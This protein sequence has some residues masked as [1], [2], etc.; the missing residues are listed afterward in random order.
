MQDIYDFSVGFEIKLHFCGKI[1]HVKRWNS[2]EK[3]YEMIVGRESMTS[4]VR[5]TYFCCVYWCPGQK[6]LPIQD[7]AAAGATAAVAAVAGSS[8][9]SGAA[10]AAIV[11]REPRLLDTDF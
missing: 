2:T 11:N 8:A 10:T 9:A 4:I 1:F 6:H 7:G 3:H 5:N